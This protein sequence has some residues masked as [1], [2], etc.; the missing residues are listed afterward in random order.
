MSYDNLQK[1]QR[2]DAQNHHKK[3]LESFVHWKPN[4]KK[5]GVTQHLHSPVL[6]GSNSYSI[7]VFLW[8]NSF[9]LF[10]QKK[11]TFT[12]NK[13]MPMTENRW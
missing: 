4:T 11:W 12:E 7:I 10:E 6:P 5:L 9:V 3:L 13:K 2:T 8:I 1:A